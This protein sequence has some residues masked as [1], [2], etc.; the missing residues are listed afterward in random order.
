MNYLLSEAETPIRQA[1]ERLVAKEEALHPFIIVEKVGRPDLF[2][3]FA[4]SRQRGLLFDVPALRI[5]LEKT[6]PKE[7]AFRATAELIVL[8]VLPD[9]RVL[10]HEREDQEP[11]GRGVL[12]WKRLF[13]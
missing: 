1:L 13:T 2:V 11:P 6:T 7:G 10:I 5:V 4:G 12:F 8:G 3:Q 9:E